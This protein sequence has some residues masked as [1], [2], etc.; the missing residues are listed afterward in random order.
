MTCCRG[1]VGTAVAFRDVVHLSLPLLLVVSAGLVPALACAQGAATSGAATRPVRLV[2]RIEAPM[3]YLSLEADPAKSGE[4]A[5]PVHRLLADPAFDSLLGKEGNSAPRDSAGRALA[6]VRGVLARSAGDVELALTGVVPN[7]GQPLLVLR[8]RLQRNEAGRMSELLAGPDLAAPQRRLGETQTYSLREADGVSRDEIGGRVELA[9]VGDDLIVANDGTAMQELLA[10]APEVTSAAPIRRVLSADPRFNQLKAQLA[11]GP[12]S[13]MLY[14]DWQR[15]S[16][17]LQASSEGVPQA[18]LSWSGLDNARTVMAALAGDDADFTGTLLLDFE[19]PAGGGRGSQF[20]GWF[21]AAESVPARSLLSTLPPGGLGGIV[22]AVDLAQIAQRSPRGARMLHELGHAFDDFG[23]D[24]ERKVLGRLGTGGTV[25][26]LF[27]EAD[28]A[29]EIVSVYS[30]RAKSKQAAS[31]LFAD[32]RRSVESHG[33]G[34]LL[35]ARGRNGAEVLELH[36]RHGMRRRD[37]GREGGGRDGGGRDEPGPPGPGPGPGPGR[38]RP[39]DVPVFVAVFEDTVLLGAD[40]DTMNVVLDEYRR[41]ARTRGKRD[42]AVNKAV[43]AIG[44]DKVAGL[45]DVDLRPLFERITNQL[46]SRDGAAAIDLSRIPQRH[47][48]YLDVQP[49]ADGAVLRIRV[50]SA[51]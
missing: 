27:R 24:F 23:L 28:G 12:G 29:P 22:M 37:D 42:A 46:V 31:A 3:L 48:G 32:L 14:G 2:D 17:R 33:S 43:A 16:R 8:A 19:V 49:R 34:K 4:S 44:G 6:L 36:H 25:Q 15:L 51:R 40:A 11:A 21:A 50:L 47:T 7:G 30:L 35:P 18:V 13:L 26:L 41:S 45:F 5:G 9:V 20:D 39:E 1:I 38:E 10:P